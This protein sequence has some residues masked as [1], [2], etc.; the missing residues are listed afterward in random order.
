MVTIRTAAVGDAVLIRK[1]VSELAD[2]EREANQVRTTEADI[3]R[4]GFQASPQFRALIAEW[5]GQPA[6]FALYFGYYSTWRGAGLYLEDLFVR[7]QFRARG[8]GT[9]LLA[10][11]ARAAEQENRT[12][13]RWSVLNWNQTAIHMYE[14]LG[15]SF[16]DDWR[17]VL[18]TGDGLRKLAAKDL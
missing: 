8:I 9:A 15:A 16:L 10:R 1:M 11:V 5:S 2:F 12:F 18:L 13:I 3:S 7:P 14:A 4:D 17:A 6:G